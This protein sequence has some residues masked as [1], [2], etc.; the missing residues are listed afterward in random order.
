V[1]VY[2]FRLEEYD[3]YLKM[4]LEGKESPEKPPEDGQAP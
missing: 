1:D 4:V 3:K 2:Y